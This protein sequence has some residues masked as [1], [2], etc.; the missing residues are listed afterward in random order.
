MSSPTPH[1]TCHTNP[2]SQT[3]YIS[4]P[5]PRTPFLSPHLSKEL[6]TAPVLPNLAHL[7][8]PARLALVLGVVLG[9]VVRALL[10]R[11]AAVDGRVAGGA[12]VE[13]GELVELDLDR[14]ARVA[15]ALPLRLVG[16]GIIHVS[17][18]EEAVREARCYSRSRRSCSSHRWPGS[19]WRSSGPSRSS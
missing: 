13:L 3:H 14:V 15:L 17:T 10:E 11:R 7:A 5:I 1:G 6:Q 19:C 16:L 9:S 18:G 12:D 8:D 2:R 4:T